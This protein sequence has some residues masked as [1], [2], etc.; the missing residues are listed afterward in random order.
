MIID[1]YIFRD[2]PIHKARPGLKLLALVILCT[3]LF[4]FEGWWILAPGLGLVA[5]GFYAAGL[6]PILAWRAIRPAALILAAIFVV[7]FYFTGLELAL[8]VV[9]RFAIL[10]IAASLVTMTTQTSQFVE[11]IM[12]PLERAPSWVPSKQIALAFA[13]AFR[14]IPRIRG[15]VADIRAA[16]AA[17]GLDRNLRALIVP[18]I[19][20]TLRDADDIAN[21]IDARSVD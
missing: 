10:I 13:L 3:V 20:K 6:A 19:L 14:F 1:T 21:A 15:H 11:A 8:F 9:L 5:I 7:Q 12:T 4:I 16:Q 18:L 17:R 2:S